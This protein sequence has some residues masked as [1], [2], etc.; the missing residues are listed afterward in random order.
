MQLYVLRLATWVGGMFTA[1]RYVTYFRRAG[2]PLTVI[3]PG[4]NREE[5]LRVVGELG[6][7]YDRRANGL[8]RPFLKTLSMRARRRL[9]R[10][11]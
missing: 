7:A 1:K 5:I 6:P 11:Q 2:Y 9:G 4:N 3:T 8:P 10:W